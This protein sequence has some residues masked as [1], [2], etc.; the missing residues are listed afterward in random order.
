MTFLIV[1]A[2]CLAG[3]MTPFLLAIHARKSGLLEK[4]DTVAKADFEALE[5]RIKHVESTLFDKKISIHTSQMGEDLVERI[6]NLAGD[7]ATIFKK[8]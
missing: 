7:V 1:F 8:I 4:F 3:I 6:D 5:A 2:A